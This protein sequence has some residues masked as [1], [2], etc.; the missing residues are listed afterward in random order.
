MDEPANHDTAASILFRDPVVSVMFGVSLLLLLLILTGTAVFA[1]SGH[2]ELLKTAL[3]LT[4]AYAV[5]GTVLGLVRGLRSARA[6]K[7][8]SA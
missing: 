3:L 4:G 6:I 8:R 7:R 2:A 5:A 1:R